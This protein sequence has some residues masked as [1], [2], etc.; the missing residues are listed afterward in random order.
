MPC[1]S[2]F[3][4]IRIIITR[5]YVMILMFPKI[6]IYVN[7]ICINMTRHRPA[8][9]L[10]VAIVLCVVQVGNMKRI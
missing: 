9:K 10:L 2:K 5:S 8:D 1:H 7:T 4:V 6:L 3:H